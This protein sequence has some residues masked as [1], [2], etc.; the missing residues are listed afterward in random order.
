M[1]R[2]DHVILCLPCILLVACGST[3]PV[4]RGSSREVPV[5]AASAEEWGP[6]DEPRADAR[7]SRA[8]DIVYASGGTRDCDAEQIACFRKCWK[9]E[10]PWPIEKG[11]KGHDK[12]CT[13]KCREEYMEC[14]KEL[15]ARPR[16]LAFPDMKTAKD[17]LARH[18]TEVL[19][20][21]I[22]VVAGATFV[23]ATGGTGALILIPLAAL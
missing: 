9:T 5:L 23:I 13:K 7:G 15:E 17:W 4:L 6:L 14:V 21:S 3:E 18:E 12:Y 20:G 2:S 22:V 8:V 19:V 11:D 1:K 16:P 10:P